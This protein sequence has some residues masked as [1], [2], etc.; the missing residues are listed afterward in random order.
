MMILWIL[1]IFIALC[2]LYALFEARHVRVVSELIESPLIPSAFEGFTFVY[3]SDLHCGKLFSP[4][5]VEKL[6]RRIN[7]LAPDAILLGGDYIAHRRYVTHAWHAL[8]HLAAPYG[9]FAV[10]GNHDIKKALEKTE[11]FIRDAGFVYLRNSG[12]HIERDSAK[13]YIAGIDDLKCGH[14]RLDLALADASE[15]EFVLL[16]SHNP[17]YV[18]TMLHE[19]TFTQVNYMLAGHTHGGQVTF[20][21]LFAPVNTSKFGNRYR[22]GLKDIDGLPLLVTNG[23][24]ANL[25][26]LRFFAPPQVHVLTLK[27]I[28]G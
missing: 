14:P 19:N 21:N 26:P 1:L 12:K 2:I 25:L 18:E 3:L 10:M 8:S 23:V 15:N 4:K 27:C 5:R 20:F 24:G 7:A 22:T 16:L 6:V 28:K 13:I 17:D 11:K 9:V